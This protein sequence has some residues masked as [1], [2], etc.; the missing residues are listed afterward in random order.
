MGRQ[1][2]KVLRQLP[3][4]SVP[5]WRSEKPTAEG[6]YLRYGKGPG[7]YH[8]GRVT[9]IELRRSEAGVLRIPSGVSVDYFS[10]DDRWIGPIPIPE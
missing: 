5:R 4:D 10:D 8:A 2:P 1:A 9:L 7:R 3:G 6:I